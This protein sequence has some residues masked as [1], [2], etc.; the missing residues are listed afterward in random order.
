[1]TYVLDACAFLAF[2]T[3]ETGWDKVKELLEQA[4]AKEITVAMS[5]VSFI[6]TYY[7]QRKSRTPEEIHEFLEL[8][9]LSPI[10]MIDTV[11]ETVIWESSRLKAL[12]KI[13]LADAIGLGTAFNL[14]DSFVTS[15]GEIKSVE[16]AES[17]DIFWFRPPKLKQGKNKADLNSVIVERDQ[18]LQRA[19]QAERALAKANRRII[20]LEAQHRPQ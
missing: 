5:V 8:F 2:V 9:A 6:E 4:S 18:A 19:E 1:M 15:N 11:V 20:A 10:K 14:S 16:T 3:K 7:D 12:Y 17:I 13:S